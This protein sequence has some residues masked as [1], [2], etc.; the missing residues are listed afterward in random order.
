MK[1]L[2][3]EPLVHFLVAGAILFV[4]YGY[5]GRNDK[6]DD[7]RI[8]VGPAQIQ[9]I[10]A[11]W[12]KQWRRLPTD[13][14]LQKLIEQF[15]QEEVLYREALALG[16]ENDDTIVRRRLAQKMK[17]LIQDIADQRQPTEGELK[18]LF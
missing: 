14:E 17:F 4:F 5:K 7:A 9:R 18:A 8:T 12:E 6:P 11:A 10:Q 1:K 13:E 3:R 2:L 16:L 15:I